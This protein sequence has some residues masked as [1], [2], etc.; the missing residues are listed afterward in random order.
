MFLT[1]F[2]PSYNRENTLPR[3]YFSLLSQSDK[4]FCWLIVDDG[5]T[6]KTEQLV[7]SWMKENKIA[8]RY[9]KQK[10]QGKSA[11]HNRGVELAESELFACVD[12][13][14]YLEDCTVS[15]LKKTWNEVCERS[16]GILAFKRSKSEIVTKIKCAEKVVYTTLKD[17]YDYLGLSGDTMLIF[18]TS[19]IKKYS[20]PQF[21]GE[22]F[23]P[24]AYLYDLIDQ[25]GKLY[26][27]PRPLYVCEYLPDGYTNNMAKLLVDNANGYLAYINQR[28]KFDK[29]I[30]SRFF[31]SIR[32]IAMAI[33]NRN[34]NIIRESV[35]PII[36]FVAYPLGKLFYWKRYRK[37]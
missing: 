12:S 5:S 30:K 6:D 28:L 11:A 1:I 35:Y 29:T 9:Y 34:S 36:A 23:V 3:L 16:V 31:D 4:D 7:A 21:E 19:I 14:D 22:K 24:E 15:E 20:F 2:T 10:N 27:F 13:D 25:E 8:I 17:A 18:R 37:F 26:L 33:A 32:Y